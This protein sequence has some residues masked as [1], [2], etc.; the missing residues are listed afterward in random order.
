MAASSRSSWFALALLLFAAL[1]ST[2][3]SA[4][5][6]ARYYD[7][8]CPNVQS[9]VRAVMAHKVT[10]DPSLAPAVLRLFFHDCFVN[11]RLQLPT[12]LRH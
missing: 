7:K 8:T 6:L 11:V 1:A 5:L 12:R 3:N 10:V 2:A 4:K 9:V